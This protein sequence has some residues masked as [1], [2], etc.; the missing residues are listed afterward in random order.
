MSKQK[1]HPI[2]AFNKLRNSFPDKKRDA[3]HEIVVQDCD[4]WDALESF[5]LF[6]YMDPITAESDYPL[7]LVSTEKLTPLEVMKVIDKK[8]LRS[9][10][11]NLELLREAKKRKGEFYSGMEPW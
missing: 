10:E 11:D 4:L 7:M 1:P 3:I 5:G 8:Y 2:E 6:H 9:E